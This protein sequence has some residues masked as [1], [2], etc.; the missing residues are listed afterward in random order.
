MSRKSSEIK[1]DNRRNKGKDSA[2]KSA[3]KKKGKKNNVK[4]AL[5]GKTAKKQTNIKRQRTFAEDFQLC[6]RRQDRTAI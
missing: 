3:S 1:E 5:K 4:K 2:K 6:K